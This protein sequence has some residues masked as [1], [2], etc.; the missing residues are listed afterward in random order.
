MF[1]TAPGWYPDPRD[2]AI[3]RWW[4]GARWTE[5]TQRAE[6]E[7]RQPT[8]S[9]QAK[10][11]GRKRDLRTEVV[12]LQQIVDSMG[13]PQ[14][15]EVRAETRRLE[16]ELPHLRQEH[17]NLTAG[18]VPM[19]AEVGLLG[20]QRAQAA[21]IQSDVQRLQEQR[22]GLLATVRET[23]QLGAN[24]SK[25]RAE[26]AE[27]AS[28]L[29]ETRETAL[30]QEAGVYQYRHPLDDSVAYKAKLKGIQAKIKDSVKAGTAVVESTTWTVNNSSRQGAKMVREISRL[31]LR[32]Y[33]NE[34]D[35]AVRGM[36]PYALESVTARLTKA[37]ETISRL[38][39]TMNIRVTENY[40]RLRV[41][42]LELTSDYLAKVAEEKDRA[43]E[44]RA[45]L[46][47][48]EIA[49]REFEREQEKLRK[50]QAHY[51]ATLNTLKE[52]GDFDGAA[53]AAA[54]LAEI[55]ES[56]DGI[57]R[58]AA[59][60]RAGHVYVISNIGAF[61]PNMVKIGLTRRLDPMDRVRE[62]GDASV[63]FRYDVHAMV[64]SDDA[65]SLETRLHHEFAERR[66]NLVNMRREFFRVSPA[67][68]RDVITRLDASIVSWVDEPEAL[69]W[70]QSQTSRREQTSVPA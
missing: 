16:D 46:R 21:G 70:R 45:R 38:G 29:V 5:H 24:I 11:P 68:V 57:N 6:P 33:N 62:L 34:A 42:E 52:Q 1:V 36:K 28:T 60:I 35:N 55:Q 18:L 66:V 26:H 39:A 12:R 22:D 47:E 14:L 13:I 63:P 3:V 31:M 54:K 30:L 48:E 4:D 64:F 40:H 65:V 25:L 49:R 32:A 27:L 58:R 53:R 41:E 7:I 8:I 10:F 59:N 61:G 56:I 51:N 50:E 2:F 44:E 19:R 67:E 37:K 9:Q 69:E 43:R 23:K 17:A 15:E 20:Q